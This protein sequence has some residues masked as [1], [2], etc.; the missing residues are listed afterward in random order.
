MKDEK[1]TQEHIFKHFKNLF[2]NQ[3]NFRLGMKSNLWTPRTDLTNIDVEFREEEI[4]KAVWEF[5]F[6]V[7]PR[8][9]GFPNFHFKIF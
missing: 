1:S 2:A 6:D 4:K 5:G 7:A 3:N 8:S 9:D